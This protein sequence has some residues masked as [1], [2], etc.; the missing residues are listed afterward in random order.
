MI[1]CGGDQLLAE[2]EAFRERLKG[3]GKRVEG[4]WLRGWGHAWDKK[5][6]FGRGDGKRD[7]A[8]KV[9]VECLQGAWGMRTD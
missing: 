6:M 2:G 1:T 7:V 4:M 3:L 8:Y 5:S 9:M